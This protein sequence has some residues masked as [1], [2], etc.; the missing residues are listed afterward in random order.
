MK[1]IF[2]YFYKITNLVN[3]KFYYGVHKTD[4][5]ADNYMGSGKRIKYAIKK[6]GI[7]NFKKEI[8]CY[9]ETYEEVL[10]YESE[11]VTVDLIQNE[12]CYNIR[13]GGLGG[14]EHITKE[15]RQNN[16]R[17]MLSILWLND[18]YMKN[19]KIRSSIRMKKQHKDG[20]MKYDTFTGKHHSND[21]IN[22]MKL[23]HKLNGD[24]IGEK[25][26]QFGTCWIR[27]KNKNKKINKNELN[28]WLNNGWIKGR[29]MK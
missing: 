22:K 14:F 2:N 25:N 1:N 4:N 13:L 3:N 26:S 16:I 17:K 21:T 20:K 11:I 19:H 18:E 29:K 12:N 8:I 7:E 23:S 15:I 9:F 6:Y 27:K 5:I 24:Q 10:K 28:I